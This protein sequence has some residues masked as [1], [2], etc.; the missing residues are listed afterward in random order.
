MPGDLLEGEVAWPKIHP[1][2]KGLQKN[3]QEATQLIKLISSVSTASLPPLLLSSII[4]ALPQA[5]L[6]QPLAPRA[7]KV[8]ASLL[9]LERGFIAK[10]LLFF[11][12]VF[13][14]NA[15]ENISSRKKPL[16]PTV[17]PSDS[18]YLRISVFI[19]LEA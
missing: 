7:L 8:L 13:F 18:C 5:P 19:K 16:N 9:T 2:V 10:Q 6:P 11:C 1:W 17:H 4:T 12:W 14:S 3:T 15:A